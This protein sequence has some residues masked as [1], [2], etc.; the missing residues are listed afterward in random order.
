MVSKEDLEERWLT[1]TTEQREEGREN[2]NKGLT[3][4]Y[5]S[6]IDPNTKENKFFQ[7]NIYPNGN[8]IVRFSFSD[9]MKM[10]KDE[11]NKIINK[12]R[13]LLLQMVKKVN[14]AITS[15][16][17]L[18]HHIT[19]PNGIPYD[20]IGSNLKKLQAHYMLHIKK[21]PNFEIEKFKHYI[22][23]EYPQFFNL[24]HVDSKQESSLFLK[25]IKTNDFIS[26]EW[27]LHGTTKEKMSEI[28]LLP[29][30]SSIVKRKITKTDK[31]G[32]IKNKF[33]GSIDVEVRDEGELSN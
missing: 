30:K 9:A 7:V 31:K 20:D 5:L 17:L 15:N 8:I 22:E 12:L 14:Y 3:F 27:S 23:N 21:P 24:S 11:M 32:E 6:H 4:Y 28:L 29:I 2:Q 25:Y 10:Q 26:Q 13:T 18:K 19:I 33:Y 1:L 16:P